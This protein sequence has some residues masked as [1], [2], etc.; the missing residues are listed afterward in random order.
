M[1]GEVQISCMPSFEYDLFISYSHIDN[2]DGDGWVDM[3]HARLKRRLGVELGREP[4]I[5]RDAKRLRGGDYFD[6]EI[7]RALAHTKI[8]LTVV[9]P[10]YLNSKYCAQELRCFTEAAIANGGVRVGNR[11]RRVKVVKTWVE[12]DRHPT[13]L[14][15]QTGYE[16]CEKDPE[17]GRPREFSQVEDG[18]KYQQYIDAVGDLVWY[19][20]ELLNDMERLLPQAVPNLMRT[21][22]LA[23]TTNDR[24]EDRGRI[25][26]ELRDRGHDVLPGNELPRRAD[27]YCGAV[28]ECLE[29]ARLSVHLIGN[30]YGTILD[31]EEEKSVV[32]LQN[33]LAAAR[34][35]EAGLERIIW[36]PP[37]LTPTGNRQQRFVEQLQIDA[38]AQRGAE[39]LQRSFEDL[40]TRIVE[41]LTAPKHTPKPAPIGQGLRDLAIVYL[42][43]DKPDFDEIKPIT[44][45]LFDRSYEVIRCAR[46]GEQEQVIQYHKDRLLECDAALIYYGNGNEFWLHSKLSELR[47]VVGWGR[48]AMIPCR[49]IYLGRPETEDKRNFKTL[50]ATLLP[51]GYGGLNEGALEYFISLIESARQGLA[52]TGTG[53]A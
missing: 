50:Q 42:I 30:T 5:W 41:K 22:Y 18:Y 3:F 32:Y 44:D 16:L 6:D 14:Q 53:G 23:E 52:P 11:S 40:K 28:S 4:R 13:E 24:A 1:H 7:E 27:A 25:A 46:E 21:I 17:S 35:R 20:A 33:E 12:R 15:G 26:Q 19:L 48:P 43:C 34:S 49:A 29:R 10:S 39:V 9:S 2:G 37:D 8:L 45:Y 47:K 38:E 51:P 36:L 31:G